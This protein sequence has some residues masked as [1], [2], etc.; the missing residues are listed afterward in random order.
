M[1]K[2]AS[3]FPC[4][5]F[6]STVTLMER[7]PSRTVGSLPSTPQNLFFLDSEGEGR[8]AG[9][10]EAVGEQGCRAGEAGREQGCRVGETGAGEGVGV[11]EG[12]AAGQDYRAGGGQG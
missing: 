10:E 3:V 4:D 1:T 8:V 2:P 5:M 6:L 7:G 9:Q 12:K 11:G